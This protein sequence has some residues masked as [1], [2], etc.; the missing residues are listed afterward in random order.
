MQWKCT[1]DREGHFSEVYDSQGRERIHEPQQVMFDRFLFFFSHFVCNDIESSIQ[2][3]RMEDR[4][5]GKERLDSSPAM[6]PH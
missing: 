4:V 5:S 1:H 6:C 2:L 3:I